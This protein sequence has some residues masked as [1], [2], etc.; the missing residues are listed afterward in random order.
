MVSSPRWTE[1]EIA[2]LLFLKRAKTSTKEI[3]R[4]MN[5]TPCQVNTQYA[6]RSSV[7][8]HHHKPDAVSKPRERESVLPVA[9]SDVVAPL[10]KA[11]LMAGR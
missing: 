5:R 6:Y 3:A 4:L 8:R 9:R 2:T 1:E 11:Q 7:I 10:T